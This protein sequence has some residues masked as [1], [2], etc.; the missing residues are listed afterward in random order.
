MKRLN[1]NVI[2]LAIGL[3]FS[4]G[5]M[6]QSMTRDQY[7]SGIKVI[8]A[9]YK[10]AKGTCA[11]LA[12]NAKDICKTGASGNEKVA[13]AELKAK[14]QPSEKASYKARVARADADYSLARQ[15]CDDQAG[16]LK[17]VCVKE[18]KAA[19]VTARANANAH[20]K[21][22]DAQTSAD[23]KSVKAQGAADQT[24]AEAQTK[25]NA[26]SAD[27]LKDATAEKRSANYAVAKE[28]CDALAGDAKGNCIKDAT[29]RFG[30]L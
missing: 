22:V 9:D 27:A 16:N 21:I 2:A 8:A 14:F 17:D 24:S 12:G 6:A 3:S 10:I 5:A 15:K 28:K 20:L 23:E 19:A 11:S 4:I 29:A 1:I 26:K 30:K 13:K 25:A 18:A 7:K